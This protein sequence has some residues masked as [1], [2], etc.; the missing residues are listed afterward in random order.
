MNDKQER[1]GRS[2]ITYLIGGI[3]LMTLLQQLVIGPLTAGQSEISYTD[4][5]VAL[6]AGEVAEVE[7]GEDYILGLLSDGQE[8]RTVRIEDVKLLEELEAQNAEVRGTVTSDGSLVGMLLG[9][10]LPL[11]VMGGL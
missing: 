4:F 8:F 11:A 10:I 9:W 2:W 7:V 5:K 3:V 6:R 1:P